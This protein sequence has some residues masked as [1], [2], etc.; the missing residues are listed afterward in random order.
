MISGPQQLPRLAR[1]A[2]QE[3]VGGGGVAVLVLPGDVAA[4]HSVHPTGSGAVTLDPP[5]VVPAAA[6]VDALATRLDAADRV[7]IMAGAGCRG[8]HHELMELADVLAAPVGHALRG[9]EFVQ[10][11][12]PFDVGMTGLLGYGACYEAMHAADLAGHVDA[13]D[14]RG[15]RAVLLDLVLAVAL[16]AGQVADP[17]LDDRGRGHR[18]RALLGAADR[19][20]RELLAIAATQLGRR[21]PLELGIVGDTAETIRAVLPKLTR[22][23]DRRFLADMLHRHERALTQ[24]VEAYTHDVERHTPIHPEYAAAELDGLAADDAIFT[25]DTGMCNVWTARYI[26]PNGRRRIL[27]SFKH[28]SMANA[29]PHAIGAQLAA[30]DRQVIAMA[31]DGGLAMLLGELLTLKTHRLP[32]KVVVFNN[33]S[34]GMVKLEMLVAGLPEYETDHDHVDFAAIAQGAGLF[35]RRVQDPAA[36]PDGIAEVLA[37][38]GPALLDLVTD[39]NALSMPPNITAEKALGFALAVSRTVLGGGVG[40]MLQLARSNLRNIPRP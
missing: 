22:K 19:Q 13:A 11:D 24:V 37:H 2:I 15:R 36:V 21:T 30:P 7:M 38:P 40:K 26:T 6:D 14:P 33:S 25:S 4:Q 10:Y 17:D 35:A 32:V 3:A 18:D 28:G 16:R 9:K 29:L 39:P 20:R 1:I 23:T 31:G 5:C 12:N 34:L 27:G 8:A